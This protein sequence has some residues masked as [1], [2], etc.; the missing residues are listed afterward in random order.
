MTYFNFFKIAPPAP[1]DP[2]VNEDTQIND[3]WDHL[4]A[5]LQPYVSGGVISDIETGQ[6]FFDIN[7]RFA[8]WNGAATRIPDNIDAAWSAWTAMPLAAGRAIQAGNT[9]RWRSNSI[10]RMVEMSG[11]I[12]FDGAAGAWP[13]GLQLCNADVAGAIPAAQQPIAGKH[14]TIGGTGLIGAGN[15]A[16]GYI[17]VDKPGGNTFVRVRAQYLGAAGGGNFIHMSQ[18]WWWY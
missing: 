4:D 3:N 14:I 9:W 7:F 10:L 18:V 12:Q 2:L 5:K 16:S 13:A 8:V 11:G 17:H 15:T 6:E 1:A